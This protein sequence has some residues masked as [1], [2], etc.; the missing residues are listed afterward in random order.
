MGRVITHI[1]YNHYLGNFIIYAFHI[2]F[3][4][5]LM[6]YSLLFLSFSLILS[7]PL[8]LS[9][10]SFFFLFLSLLPACEFLVDLLRTKLWLCVYFVDFGWPWFGSHLVTHS[11]E[12]SKPLIA[13]GDSWWWVTPIIWSSW[14]HMIPS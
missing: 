7:L 9:N 3:P 1:D 5:F 11:H 8:F 4:L 6:V 13:C 12:L 10:F 14:L 2:W